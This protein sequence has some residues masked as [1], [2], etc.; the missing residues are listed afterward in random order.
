MGA[1]SKPASFANSFAMLVF[2]ALLVIV[3]PSSSPYFRQPIRARQTYPE[4]MT[5]LGAT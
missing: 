3:S 1:G 4:G 2:V 5:A